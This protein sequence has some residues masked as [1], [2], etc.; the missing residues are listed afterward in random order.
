[1]TREPCRVLVV[2]DSW[3]IQQLVA[4][5]LEPMGYEVLLAGTIQAALETYHRERPDVVLMDLV[6]PHSDGLSGI[7][8]LREID[9]QVRV[10]VL[11]GL[12]DDA[13]RR[14]AQEAG[15]SVFLSKP[16]STSRLIEAIEASQFG[17]APVA[18]GLQASG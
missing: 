14:T 17:D 9:P 8:R 4:A 2:D 11:S 3:Y 1:M 16:L 18:Q 12:T 13:I 7:A 5:A 10:V 6:L 15:A